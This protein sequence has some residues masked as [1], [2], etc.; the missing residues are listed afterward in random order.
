MNTVNTF[1]DG[2]SDRKLEDLDPSPDFHVTFTKL[3]T[4]ALPTE[5]QE[6]P[7]SLLQRVA[8]RLMDETSVVP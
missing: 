1:T 6:Y 4:S 5:K 3:R 7:S 8:G 2:S